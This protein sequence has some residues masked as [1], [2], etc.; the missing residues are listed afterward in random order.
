VQESE[1]TRLKA[2]HIYV[3]ND[4]VA[5][6]SLPPNR[7]RPQLHGTVHLRTG[8]TARLADQKTGKRG[9]DVAN[10][11]VLIDL[12]TAGQYVVC[13]QSASERD[14]LLEIIE[15]SKSMVLILCVACV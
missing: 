1:E 15:D 6:A 12:A 14:T 10:A 5:L 13:L 2:A 7:G 4:L 8:R 9:D 3:F 11:L